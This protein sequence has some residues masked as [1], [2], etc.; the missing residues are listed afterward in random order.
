MFRRYEK[1]QAKALPSEKIGSD[2]LSD[3]RHSTQTGTPLGKKKFKDE[4]EALLQVKI[5]YSSQGRPRKIK[6]G[7]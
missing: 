4:I 2:F 1:G 6:K 5:G 7:S 3:I